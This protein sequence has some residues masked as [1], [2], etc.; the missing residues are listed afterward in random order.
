MNFQIPS[1]HVIIQE[2]HTRSLTSLS[3]HCSGKQSFSAI[4][5]PTRR[6]LKSCG[7]K[8]I[9]CPDCESKDVTYYGYSASGVQ[10]YFCKNCNYQ[11]VGQFDALFPRSRRRDI[12]EREFLS[13]IK[14]AGFEKGSGKQQYWSGAR[15]E[16]LQML[17]SSTI[18]IRFKKMLKQHPLFGESDYKLMLEF[19]LH[20]AYVRVMA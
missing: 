12:F 20:E 10:K 2:G 6:H 15:L 13:N 19:I 16:T 18:R 1:N 5:K 3:D 17:E 9:N 7:L 14:P 8:Y 4:L 11:F